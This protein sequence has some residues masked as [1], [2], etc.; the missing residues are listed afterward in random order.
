MTNNPWKKIKN[1]GKKSNINGILADKNNILEFYWAKDINGSLLFVMKTNSKLTINKLPK[2]NGISLKIGTYNNIEQL[3][4]TLSSSE[5]KDIFYTL[6]KDLIKSSKNSTNEEIAVKI[7]FRRLEKWQYFLKNS[8]K[9]IDKRQLKGLV[10]ELIFIKEHLLHRYSIDESL[11]FWK[12]PLKSVQDFEFNNLAVEVKTK[13]SVNSITI[14]SF[15]QLYSEYKNLLLYVVTLNES[16]DKEDKSF[17][18]FDLINDIKNI[19]KKKNSLLE[20]KFNSLLMDYGFLDIEEYSEYYFL[21]IKD[22]FYNVRDNFP[23]IKNIPYG[24]EKLTYKINL[25]TCKEF[26]VEDIPII[27][28]GD[29]YE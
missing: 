25:D 15:E 10:G 19:I 27:F 20:E 13:G 2:L 1:S 22:E 5:D 29:K 23:K 18:I 17:N 11:N 16:T 9:I 12:A 6:C 28:N 24:V 26:L 14:S 21:F 4:F 8:K 3:I 7:I